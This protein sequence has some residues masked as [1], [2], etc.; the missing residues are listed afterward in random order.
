MLANFL[1]GISYI[2]THTNRQ[3]RKLLFV[4]YTNQ[5]EHW[6]FRD[7]VHSDTFNKIQERCKKQKKTEIFIGFLGSINS[8]DGFTTQS[9]YWELECN[10]AF[11]SKVTRGLGKTTHCNFSALQTIKSRSVF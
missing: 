8:L 1:R 4:L 10:F 9:L 3:F 7:D 11:P 2:R 6:G 5:I